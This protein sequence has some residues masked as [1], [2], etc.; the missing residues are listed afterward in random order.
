MKQ[1]L[2][3]NNYLLYS[4]M[5][6]IKKLLTI[7]I[8]SH[9]YRYICIVLSYILSFY[10]K[11]Y[12][13]NMESNGS[14]ISINNIPGS[15]GH[16]TIEMEWLYCELNNNQELKHIIFCYPSQ[17][18]FDDFIT[19][20][21]NRDDRIIFI[22]SKFKNIFYN[23]VAIAFP[24]ISISRSVSHTDILYSLITWRREYAW[25]YKMH[26]I[27]NQYMSNMKP[28]ISA[29]SY[30]ISH[31]LD[32]HD[33]VI[34]SEDVYFALQIKNSV[35]NG[36]YNLFK[37]KLII[38]I[39]E[40]FKDLGIKCVLVGRE[41]APDY[42]LDLGVIKYANSSD[43]S[44]SNDFKIINKAEFVVCSSSGFNFIPC[45]LD[46]PTLVYGVP[47]LSWPSNCRFLILP[48]TV[49]NKASGAK[50][51]FHEQIFNILTHGKLVHDNAEKRD[52][53]VNDTSPEELVATLDELLALNTDNVPEKSSLQKEFDDYMFSTGAYYSESRVSQN[54]LE[55]NKHLIQI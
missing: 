40:Y 19:F 48:Q 3:N 49:S 20:F 43:A 6:E 37:K 4:L 55:H 5:V 2:K 39:I 52:F 30:I 38:H 34:D 1:Y 25:I 13:S 12:V 26:K 24:S 22:S 28:K 7:E 32:D 15:I 16:M 54:F 27:S 42:L 50:M 47:A 11:Q 31:N 21:K 44:V 35:G 8:Y 23:S 46:K 53:I 41:Q 18:V 9:T 14:R 45:V 17:T 33:S 36:T 29:S 51:N 10:G